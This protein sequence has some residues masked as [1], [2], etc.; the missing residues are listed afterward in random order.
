MSKIDKTVLFIH[1]LCSHANAYRNLFDEILKEANDIQIIAPDLIGH[2]LS[3]GPSG[4]SDIPEHLKYLNEFLRH[5]NSSKQLIE[6]STLHV[7]GHSMGGLIA[8]Y[9]SEQCAQV[10]STIVCNP[11]FSQ[12]SDISLGYPQSKLVTNRYSLKLISSVTKRLVPN[13]LNTGLCFSPNKLTIHNRPGSF[14][15]TLKDPLNR[16]SL[17]FSSLPMLSYY[18]VRPL[19]NKTNKVFAIHS[20]E[21]EITPY[22]TSVKA[23]YENTQKIDQFITLTDVGHEIHNEPN[24]CKILTKLILKFLET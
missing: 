18:I 11:A 19:P 10:Q 8:Y 3:S 17:T 21:D 1:G 13:C 23:I 9:F 14:E 4:Y 2:G 20:L 22:N 12:A 15:R 5:L 16:L 24:G 6:S 7:I